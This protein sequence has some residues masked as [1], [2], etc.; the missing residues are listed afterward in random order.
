MLLQMAPHSKGREQD[1]GQR[2]GDVYRPDD[3]WR[4]Q[5]REEGNDKVG[6]E[7]RE[8]GIVYVLRDVFQEET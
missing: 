2:E 4:R 1:D 3:L 5:A 6:T 7:C 8:E